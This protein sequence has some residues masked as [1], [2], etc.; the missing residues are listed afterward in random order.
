MFSLA[1]VCLFVSRIT[2]EQLQ[3]IFTEF[4]GNVSHGP[5]MKLLD[6]GSN[7]DYVMLRLGFG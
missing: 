6:F 1:F 5:Q 7:P 3:P 4:G 2:Q